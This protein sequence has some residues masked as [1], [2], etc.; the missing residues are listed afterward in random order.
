MQLCLE[1]LESRNC[2]SQLTLFDFGGRHSAVVDPQ[3]PGFVRALANDQLPWQAHTP[4]TNQQVAA[5]LGLAS[6]AAVYLDFGDR[7]VVTIPE[8]MVVDL[9]SLPARDL[10]LSTPD[11]T[12]F[13]LFKPAGAVDPLT[14]VIIPAP[15]PPSAPTPSAPGLPATPATAPIVVSPPLPQD[16]VDTA[17]YVAWT[18]S[19]SALST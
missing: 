11:S 2:P 13:I 8:A 16:A 9:A 1:P 10:V 19:H 5:G 3:A 7:A 18:H 14:P 6:P 15:L 17:A 12:T 4:P